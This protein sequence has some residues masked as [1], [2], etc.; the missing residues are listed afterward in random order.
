[1]CQAL[2]SEKD[3]QGC[4]LTSDGVILNMFSEEIGSSCYRFYFTRVF[5]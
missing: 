1:M 3:P 5:K 2:A 4:S